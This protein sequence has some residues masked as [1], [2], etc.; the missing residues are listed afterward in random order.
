MNVRH[1]LTLL[2]VLVVTMQDGRLY[3]SGR[4]TDTNCQQY[5]NILRYEECTG[6]NHIML[7]HLFP[8]VGCALYKWQALE[9][10]RGFF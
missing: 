2:A 10:I 8:W 3:I 7:G 6:T 1:L 9:C 5:L 4:L